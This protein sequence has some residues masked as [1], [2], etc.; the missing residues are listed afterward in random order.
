MS[1]KQI[2]ERL[3]MIRGFEGL[4]QF[5]KDMYRERYHD[6]ATN[7]DHDAWLQR[8]SSSYSDDDQHAERIKQYINSYWFHPSTPI[9]S[10]AGLPTKGLPIS[11]YT[12]AVEDSK[13]GIFATWEEN[14]WLG[15]YGGGIGTT[16]RSVREIGANIGGIGK[17]SGI[18]PFIKVSDSTTLAVSQGGLRRASQAVYIDIDH[19]E[20]GEFIDVRRPT[21]DKDRRSTNIHH[22]IAISDAFMEAV[23]ARAS[24]DLVSPKTREVVKTV[25]AFDL[26]KKILISRV[27]TGEPYLLFIDTVN[28]N[29]PSEYIQNHL[30]VVTSNLCSEITLYT[31]DK[32]SGVC[33]LTS[34]NLEYWDEFKDN[35]QFFEDIHRYT[36]NVL[37]SFIDLTKYK[38]GFEKTRASAR[39][40]RSLGIG[41]MGFHQYLQKN[42]LPFGSLSS[43]YINKTIFKTIDG[44]FKVTNRILGLEKGPAPL[45][46][47]TSVKRNVHVT[48]IAP[49]A[50]I[51]TLCNLSSPG[52][53]PRVANVYTAKTNIGA[54]TIKNKFLQQVMVDYWEVEKLSYDAE[55]LIG[56]DWYSEQ[57]KS[58]LKNGGSVQHLTWMSAEDKE[59]FLTAYEID[60]QWVVKYA[61]DRAPYIDQAASTNLFIPANV[62]VQKLYNLHI[63]AWRDGVKSLYYLRS[64]SIN[65]A[66]IEDTERECLSCQ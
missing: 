15:S 60:N 41:V 62:N 27:E 30:S 29:A 66:T 24:W 11:C 31:D 8:V 16:W 2:T 7:E 22:G 34:M 12:N 19:P 51:S 50:S 18:I 37:Q 59:V 48:A 56:Y 5:S 17:S 65:R 55:A 6:E 45:C 10:N 42:N 40:E 57:W 3:A 20:I 13:D 14:N 46:N 33:C 39:R 32:Y 47:T 54:Y 9:S 1:I 64:L 61:C 52:I 26:F 4:P 53:D 25:D 43:D 38:K 35:A 28:R 44:Y 49:T 23:E 63:Q 58:I 21:G 36:D